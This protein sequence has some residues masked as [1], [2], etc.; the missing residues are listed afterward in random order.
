MTREEERIKQIT[1]KLRTRG[2]VSFEDA[3]FIWKMLQYE[4]FNPLSRH[5]AGINKSLL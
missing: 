4:K 5:Y 2:D 1:K 3:L